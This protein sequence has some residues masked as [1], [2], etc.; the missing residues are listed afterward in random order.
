M[1]C[2]EA[3]SAEREPSM[4]DTLMNIIGRSDEVLAAKVS[5]SQAVTVDGQK[6]IRASADV[7]DMF[8]GSERPR[9]INYDVEFAN[10]ETPQT[11]EGKTYILF[12]KKGKDG[13]RLLED[14]SR[15]L[16]VLP[17]KQDVYFQLM[18]DYVAVAAD[19]AKKNLKPHLF[20]ALESGIPFF[21]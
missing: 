11:K 20:K 4:F 10:K 2:A 16:G 7:V 13:R 15:P 5:G 19:V 14:M 9:A 3:R 1:G 12:L 8:K 21:Q 6:F 18:G 17:D